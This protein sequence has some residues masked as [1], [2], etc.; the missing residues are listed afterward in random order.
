MGTVRHYKDDGSAVDETGLFGYN[1]GA[2]SI[3]LDSNTGNATFGIQGERAGAGQIN[4][5]PS[6]GTITGGNYKYDEG[7]DKKNNPIGT[8]MKI[9]L[10]KV[11]YENNKK[12]VTGPSI[13]FGSGRFT[14]NSKG[15]LT[16]KGG[17]HIAGWEIGDTA[18]T[19]DDV[20]MSSD[21]DTGN[22]NKNKAFWAGAKESDKNNAPFNVNFNGD[23]VMT[24][25]QIG[26]QDKNNKED[27]A[28][29]FIKNGR[30]YTEGHDH[31]SDN[32]DGF[33]IGPYGIKLGGTFSV[34]KEGTLTAQKG[35]IGDSTDGFWIDNNAI[36][37]VGKRDRDKDPKTKSISKN[38]KRGIRL[39]KTYISLGPNA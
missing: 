26:I 17:G 31:Y 36:C 35:Y 29:I 4:I 39:T 7:V 10:G 18:L 2:R 32:K 13:V 5:T 37:T 30:I 22:K 14:V 27:T 25:A 16:A 21:N 28:N 1:K 34:S 15:H 20:G 38:G 3:F 12:I 9:D 19:K 24:S 11:T 6:Q 8:G 33:Y 23:V